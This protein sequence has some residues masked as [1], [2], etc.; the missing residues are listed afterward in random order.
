MDREAF[1]R[2]FHAR[3]PGITSRA[4]ARGGSYERLAAHVE[5]GTRTLDLACGDGH[6]VR[7]LRAR[8]C[9]AV[10][11][12][13]AIEE[14]RLAGGACARAQQLPFAGAAFGAV[15]S[16]LAFMLFDDLD[17]VVAEL[18]R[19]L[20]PGGRFVAALGG[21]PTADGDDAFHQF[22]ALAQ[23]HLHAHRFGDPRA[24]TEAGWRTLFAGWSAIRFERV[25]LDLTGTFAEVW[26][27][28]GASYQLDPSIELRAQLAAITGTERVP[29]E[30]V[31]WIATATRP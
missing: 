8:G 1:L 6:L 21:G 26:Q 5:P 3:H 7:L 13:I 16:H 20:V 27:F 4:L 29:C 12:D 18:A 2:R 24:N 15:V 19:V 17:R 22:L 14:A 23:P 28:L 30:V 25:V 9:D 31:I 11:V 10:G